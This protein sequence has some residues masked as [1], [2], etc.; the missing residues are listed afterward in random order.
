MTI[1]YGFILGLICFIASGFL[2]AVN[3]LTK[4]RIIAQAQKQEEMTLKAVLSGAVR[5]EP[6]KSDNDVIYYKGYDNE[7]KLLGI[8]FKAAGKGYSSVIETMSGLSLR[9]TITAIKILNQN[10][11][12]GLGNR[13][14]EAP[15]LDRFVNKSAWDLAGVQAISGATISSRAV[16]DS[17]KRKA[18]E[19]QGLV[20]NVPK[21]E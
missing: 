13:I 7:G 17:V 6:I 9:G 11:T 2:A 10:E 18:A 12:P 1:R 15:F 21:N 8:A 14:T 4:A 3:S 16:I 19:I 5:F 20:K